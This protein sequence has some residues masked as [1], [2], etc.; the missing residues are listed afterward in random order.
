MR[1][2]LHSWAHLSFRC[3][4]LLDS[5]VVELISS[6]LPPVA[7]RHQLYCTNVICIN[8]LLIIYY[9]PGQLLSFCSIK[10]SYMERA[11]HREAAQL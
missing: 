11:W 2:L 7:Y 8:S 4:L 1:Y 9:L 6:V 10:E 3:L 5:P